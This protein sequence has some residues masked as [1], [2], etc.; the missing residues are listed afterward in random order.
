MRRKSIAIRTGVAF[1]ALALALSPVLAMEAG[2]SGGGWTPVAQG[3]N[4]AT[5]PGVTVFGATP[6]STPEQVS[7]I[8]DEQNKSQLEANVERGVSQD[9][10]VS[11]FAQQYGQSQSNISALT[12]Y[13]KKFGITSTVYADN[14]DVST[15]G[16]AGD[17]DAA[18]SVQQDQYHVPSFPGY[19]GLQGR[20]A[21]TVHGA[22]T[23]PE[24]P[25]QLA[26][27]VLAVLGLSNYEPFSS[28]A[29]HNDTSVSTP[30]KGNTNACLA[31]TGLPD[32]CNTVKNFES[33]YG[34]TPLE[35]NNAGAGQTLGIVTLAGLDVGAPEYYWQ[36]IVG[37]PSTGRTVTVENIDGGAVT[38]AAAGSGETD[39][40][41]E[42]SGGIANGA[43]VIVYQAPNTDPGFADSF[44]TAASQ[45]IAGSVSSSWGESET[46]IAAA[47]TA[48]EETSAYV[49]A[50][51]EAFLELAAQGQATFVSAG[52]AAAYDASEDLLTTNLSVDAP[53]DSPYV[54]SSG[55][56]TLPFS[57]TFSGTVNGKT[58]T[59][60]VQVN[61]QR[62]WGWDYLWQPIATV[63]G[64]PL[65]TVAESYVVGGGGGFSVDE[66]TPSY[67]QQI[68]GFGSYTAVQWLTP[69]DYTDAYGIPLPEEWNFNPTPP[70]VHGYS[71]G[72]AEPDLATDA[73]PESGYLLYSPTFGTGTAELEGAWGG[74]SFV[75]PEL[76]GSTAV[77][78]ASLGHR[79]GFW[80]PSIYNFATSHNS[81]FTPLQ[82][83]GTSND[84]I[85]YTGNPGSVYNESTGLG[86]PNLAALAQDFGGGGFGR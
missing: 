13:L 8:L 1:C 36:N 79:V 69:T 85:F 65:A 38:S 46:I 39:L 54:T 33:N 70:V 82:T 31:L 49:A 60:N 78:D 24:L 48:G 75:A 11:Q 83:V 80:N 62:A 12:S 58:V 66:P 63:S 30:E 47:V 19:G 28:N 40:D 61:Q 7:F 84:N 18:L 57:A 34:L 23:S 22:T 16:T 32:A 59:A 37:L 72:R 81:P 53:G 73:D 76:N 86:I 50:F 15:T 17:Y 25:S 6:S 42:Q 29:V 26:S 64:E 44:F 43:N 9:L 14:V 55:G 3:F 5:L 2:A 41:V 51:D 10:S 35:S 21:Q 45:N 68:P 56:T 77:I 52:D 27:F 67:Q 71:S 20:P 4:P 74:T